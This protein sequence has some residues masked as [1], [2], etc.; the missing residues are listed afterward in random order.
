MSSVPNW[1]RAREVQE[2]PGIINRGNI[3]M[4]FFQKKVIRRRDGATSAISAILSEGVAIEKSPAGFSLPA[5]LRTPAVK[6]DLDGVEFGIEVITPEH[7]KQYLIHNVRNR[8]FKAAVVAEYVR[9]MKC[10][11]WCFTGEAIIFDEEDVLL[12]GQHRL[13]AIVKAGVELPFLVVRGVSKAA[14]LYM[15][16]GS[17]RNGKD[18][19]NIHDPSAPDCTQPVLNKLSSIRSGSGRTGGSLVVQDVIDVYDA[20]EKA[21][22]ASAA[23]MGKLKRSPMKIA[24]ANE[25]IPLHMEFSRSAGAAAANDFFTKVLTGAGIQENTWEKHLR[26]RLVSSVGEKADSK[27]YMNDLRKRIALV[28]VWNKIRSNAPVTRLKLPIAV[29]EIL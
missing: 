25:C 6:Q 21:L 28:S 9:S 12:N 29:P 7:A 19:L 14:F 26:D 20:E 10:N 15:D 5:D 3:V 18:A 27:H 4:D 8:K 13:M 1:S 11:Q 17:R 16:I 23:L 24:N 22:K 2:D